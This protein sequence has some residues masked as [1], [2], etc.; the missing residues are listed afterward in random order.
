MKLPKRK[1]GRQSAA[2]TE[3]YKADRLAF[4]N[5]LKMIQAHIDFK[6][7]ARGWAYYLEGDNLINKSQFNTVEKLINGFRK[8]GTLPIDFTARDKARA[9]VGNPQ[10]DYK[11]MARE[12]DYQ[13]EQVVNFITNE[14]KPMLLCDVTK[15]YIE[16]IVEKVDLV[17]LFRP[18]CQEYQIPVTN[19][20]GWSDINSRADIIGRCREK[21]MTGCDTF[22]LYCGDFDPAGIYIS[23]QFKTNMTQLETAVGFSTDFI[24]FERFGLNYDYISENSLVWTD[25]LMTG[26]GNDLSSPKHKDHNKPYVQKYIR[27]YGTQK[28]EANAL[29]KD[30]VK[31]RELML[32]KINSLIRKNSL[33][34]YN[35][36]LVEPRERL[37]KGFNKRWMI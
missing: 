34:K 9:I 6:M 37:L 13:R 1:S 32:N 15:V 14:Y 29:L 18:V 33:D 2:A 19:L 30:V 31:A 16:V 27:Q 7:S 11:D 20:R 3:Q 22:L 21:A 8:D 25:N 26:N 36:S 5:N 35:K 10:L 23:E 4:A 24:N 28:V 12:L 17:G